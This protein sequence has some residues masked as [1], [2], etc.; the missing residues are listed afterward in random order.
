[1]HWLDRIFCFPETH[2]RTF[3]VMLVIAFAI[4]VFGTMSR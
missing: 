3:N 4:T 1:M 2:P